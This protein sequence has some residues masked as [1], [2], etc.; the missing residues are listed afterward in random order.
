MYMQTLERL[1]EGTL[2]PKIGLRDCQ[3][4]YKVVAKSLFKAHV[5]GQLKNEI[6]T[7]PKRFVEIEPEIPL[8]LLDQ[9]EG[10]NV[11]F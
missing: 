5:A 8:T 10:G 4:L 7:K 11:F 3:G 9:K 2:P 1:D 6:I